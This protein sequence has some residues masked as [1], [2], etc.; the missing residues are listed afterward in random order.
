VKNLSQHLYHRSRKKITLDTNCWF[1]YLNEEGKRVKCI[2]EYRIMAANIRL[3]FIEHYLNLITL[4][5]NKLKDLSS[6]I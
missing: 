6:N 2:R 5:N 3:I 1:F 4:K